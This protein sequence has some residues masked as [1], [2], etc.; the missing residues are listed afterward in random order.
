MNDPL[1]CEEDGQEG[2]EQRRYPG[3]GAA[4]DGTGAASDGPSRGTGASLSAPL[5]S[6]V[7]DTMTS[8]RLILRCC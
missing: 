3:M 6:R 7:I 5:V 1:R 8:R 2:V 4:P